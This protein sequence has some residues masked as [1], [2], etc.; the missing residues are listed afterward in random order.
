MDRSFLYKKW[1]SLAFYE[2]EASF[3]SINYEVKWLMSIIR[4]DV[5]ICERL[6]I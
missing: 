1:N 5:D 2:N 4:R 6:Y 3:F